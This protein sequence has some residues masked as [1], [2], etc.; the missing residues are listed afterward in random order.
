MTLIGP[1]HLPDA[2]LASVTP[3]TRKESYLTAQTR[4]LG[5]NRRT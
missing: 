3:A 2:A 4:Y 1:N 5:S